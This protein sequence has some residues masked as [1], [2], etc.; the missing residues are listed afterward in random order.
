M[1]QFQILLHAPAN[2]A[3]MLV[4]IGLSFAAFN[5][6]RLMDQLMF[7]VSRIRTKNEWYRWVTSAFIHGDPLHLFLNMLA[8]FFFGPILELSFGMGAFL[9]LYFGT[10]IAAS[11]WTWMEHFRDSNYRAVGASGAI[12]GITTAVAMFAPFQE[13][14]VFFAFPMPLIVFAI[15]YILWSAIGTAGRIRD[16]IGHSAHLG[17]ALAGVAIV[18]IFWPEAPQAMI[19][20]FADKIRGL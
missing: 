14:Y 6:V 18:C 1:D 9:G 15:C 16:G 19:T 12:S 13:V 7:D 17:G 2:M 5:N 10:M 20:E 11:A 3:I 8:L 4:N